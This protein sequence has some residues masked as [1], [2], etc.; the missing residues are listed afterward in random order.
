MS[1]RERITATGAG[2]S[3]ATGHKAGAQTAFWVFGFGSLMWDPGFVYEAVYPA[4][5]HGWHRRYSLM[6]LDSWGSHDRPGLS[7]AL[8]GGG[9]VAGRVFHVAP[10]DVDRSLAYL[11]NR[12]GAYRHIDVT[13]RIETSA[14]HKQVVARTFAWDPA[15]A[16]FAPDLAI[17]RQGEMIAHGS[18]RKGTS[19]GYLRGVIEAL[20]ADGRRCRLSDRLEAHLKAANL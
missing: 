6:S 10:K 12:E 1:A 20:A 2:D 15:N 14:V 9:S 3:A 16:R 17:E 7:A 8:H 18:G 5:V 19:L 11:A 13:A 4:I